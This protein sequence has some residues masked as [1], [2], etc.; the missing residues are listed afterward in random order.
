MVGGER[1]AS[2]FDEVSVVHA[3][4]AR[5]LAAAAL[6]AR[7]HEFDERIVYGSVFVEDR[8]HRRNASTWRQALFAGGSVGGAMWQA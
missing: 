8:A 2:V 1:L 4:R 7:F 3:R 5:W 6:H